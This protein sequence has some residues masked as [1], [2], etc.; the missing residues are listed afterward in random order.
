[1][2]A[3]ES[4]GDRTAANQEIKREARNRLPAQ[5]SHAKKFR[6][7]RNAGAQQ[8]S[9]VDCRGGG[10]PLAQ[11]G[12]RR[13]KREE[14]EISEPYCMGIRPDVGASGA[15]DGLRHHVNRLTNDGFE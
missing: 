13:A 6:R 7:C 5:A 14:A 9:S 12:R 8:A 11:K 10:G 4:V 2:I 15:L 1:M 3:V